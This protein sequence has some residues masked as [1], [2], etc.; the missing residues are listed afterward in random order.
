[1]SSFFVVNS[2]KNAFNAAKIDVTF[3]CHLLNVHFSYEINQM[4]DE[5]EMHDWPKDPNFQWMLIDTGCRMTYS[6][7]QNNISTYANWTPNDY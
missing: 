5:W 7:S 1:M 3:V 4:E 2:F 6:Y